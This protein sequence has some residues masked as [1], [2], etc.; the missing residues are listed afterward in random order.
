MESVEYGKDFSLKTKKGGFTVL[1]FY[2]RDSTP[3][4]TM[5]AKDF[6]AN[7]SKFSKLKTRIVGVSKDSLAS[8]EKF[9]EK[10]K[11]KIELVADGEGVL[12]KKFDVIQMKSLYGKKFLGIERSTFILDGNGKIVHEWRK[13]KVPGHVD[14]VLATLKDLQ[15]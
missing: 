12:C 5:E 13:V 2:P 10:Q 7:L 9:R 14:E 6:T 1:Y 11:L 15:K 3:G 8:H 4:C